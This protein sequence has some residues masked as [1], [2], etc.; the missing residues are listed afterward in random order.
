MAISRLYIVALGHRN[1]RDD[2]RA[3]GSSIIVGGIIFN[4]GRD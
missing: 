3:V 1:F 2:R 4:T